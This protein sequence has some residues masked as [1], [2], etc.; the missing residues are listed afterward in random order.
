MIV[1]IGIRTLD[2][3]VG[4]HV[5]Y[6]WTTKEFYIRILIEEYNMLLINTQNN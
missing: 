5:L 6:H 4:R 2:P 3:M 1:W